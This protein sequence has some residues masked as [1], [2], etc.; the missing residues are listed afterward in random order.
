MTQSWMRMQQKKTSPKMPIG[1]IHFVGEFSESLD[2]LSN[3][4]IQLEFESL[5]ILI[6]RRQR[7]T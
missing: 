7:K 5:A 4:F 3:T 6:H 1:I 2:L